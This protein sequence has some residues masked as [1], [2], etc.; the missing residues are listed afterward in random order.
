LSSIK[1]NGVVPVEL[2]QHT[3]GSRNGSLVGANGY[4]GAI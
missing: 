4:N 3:N 1:T 2:E